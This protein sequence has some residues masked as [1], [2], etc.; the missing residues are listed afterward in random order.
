MRAIALRGRG[1]PVELHAYPGARHEVPADLAADVR[2]C[3]A[4]RLR[5]VRAP[6]D[7]RYPSALAST[8]CR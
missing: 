8:R 4:R 3:A 2:A 5:D 6:C 1:Y 7:Q